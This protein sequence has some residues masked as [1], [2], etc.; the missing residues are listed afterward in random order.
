VSTYEE[1]AYSPERV[2]EAAK[3][4]GWDTIE[5]CVAELTANGLS[6][7]QI[8][9]RLKLSGQ[10]FWAYWKV[11]CKDNAQPLRLGDSDEES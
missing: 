4:A 3:A 8:A 5:D 9:E 7:T 2:A 6:L 1:S 10:P 11:W